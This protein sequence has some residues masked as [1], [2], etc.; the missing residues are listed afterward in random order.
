MTSLKQDLRCTQAAD[1]EGTGCIKQ[2]SSIFVVKV[3]VDDLQMK[4]HG[5]TE[6]IENAAVIGVGNAASLD[7]TIDDSKVTGLACDGTSHTSRRVC[8]AV[9][10]DA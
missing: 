3:G 7:L 2:Q 6:V 8:H 5:R 10:E 1:V 4:L 9:L